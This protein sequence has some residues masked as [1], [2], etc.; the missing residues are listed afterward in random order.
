MTIGFG[1]K[2][3]QELA[4]HLGGKLIEYDSGI[5]LA[6]G[7]SRGASHFRGLSNLVGGYLDSVPKLL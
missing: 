3:K 6:R 7:H 2:E 4:D 5:S 1:P